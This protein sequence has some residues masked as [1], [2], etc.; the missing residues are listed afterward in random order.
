MVNI[1][2]IANAQKEF[3]AMLISD[4]EFEI[5]VDALGKFY[6]AQKSGKQN[7][8]SASYVGIKD[9]E[10]PYIERLHSAELLSK[11]S[12]GIFS[13]Y[14]VTDKGK[15]VF[16]QLSFIQAIAERQEI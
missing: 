11:S 7:W 3:K 13:S 8:Y 2:E 14:C 1:E 12:V 16:E 4:S 10:M 6:R 9:Y 5:A 15:A